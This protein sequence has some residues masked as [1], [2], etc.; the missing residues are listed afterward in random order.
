M[1]SRGQCPRGGGACAP[2]FHPSKFRPPPHTWMAG[3]GP[4]SELS[5]EPGGRFTNSEGPSDGSLSHAIYPY[6]IGPTLG[7]SVR[8]C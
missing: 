7:L 8:R 1:T 2:V 5:Y 6:Q 4:E 3:Y